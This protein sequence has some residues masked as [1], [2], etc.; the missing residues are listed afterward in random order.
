M[1]EARLQATHSAACLLRCPVPVTVL[2]EAD[3]A[4]VETV[5][6]DHGAISFPTAAGESYLVRALGNASV[7]ASH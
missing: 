2:H 6:G 1:T 3:A 7:E 5:A 4:E